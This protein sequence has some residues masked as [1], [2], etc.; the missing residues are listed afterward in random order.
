MHVEAMAPG[1]LNTLCKAT[2]WVTLL[3]RRQRSPSPREVAGPPSLTPVV[4]WRMWSQAV[5]PGQ[6]LVLGYTTRHQ[7]HSLFLPAV[8]WMV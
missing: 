7:K 4:E 1:H 8:F 5:G 6:V 3:L 2:G